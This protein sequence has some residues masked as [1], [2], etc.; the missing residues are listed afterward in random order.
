ML[1]PRMTTR[2]W[3]IAV[4]VVALSFVARRYGIG[5][6]H[7]RARRL[8]Q[9]KWH[10]KAEA[11]YRRQI[12]RSTARGALPER[13]DQGPTG[14]P[15]TSAV[16]DSVIERE[17]GLPAAR[18]I[19]VNGDDRFRAAQARSSALEAS[20]RKLIDELG[21]KQTVYGRKLADY[22]AGLARKYLAAAARPW[23]SVAPDP[24]VPE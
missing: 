7:E 9:A 24:P 3:M 1:L 23:L 19:P 15:G 22:H 14:V 12:T 20:R 8:A 5:L 6:K 13:A 17:F 10:A 21:R 11:D 4:A 2:R 16:L 18:S